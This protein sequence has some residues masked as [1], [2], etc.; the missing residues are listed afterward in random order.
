[1]LLKGSFVI[2]KN[3]TLDYLLWITKDADFQDGSIRAG[4]SAKVPDKEAPT[5]AGTGRHL[6]V[7]HVRV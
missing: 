3:I 5:D 4:E 7:L 1:M 6:C 2:D